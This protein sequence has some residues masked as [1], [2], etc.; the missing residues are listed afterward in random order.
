M[1]RIFRSLLI[2]LM[3][4]LLV[5]SFTTTMTG[6]TPKYSKGFDESD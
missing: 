5:V 2:A 4:G 3:I 1:K 6:C